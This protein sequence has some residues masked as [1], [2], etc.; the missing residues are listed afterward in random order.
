M[1]PKMNMRLWILSAFSQMF[2][3]NGFCH[4]DLSA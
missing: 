2:A 4:F 3:R 1:V